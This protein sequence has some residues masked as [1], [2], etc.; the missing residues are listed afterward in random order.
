MI[1]FVGGFASGNLLGKHEGDEEVADVDIAG[2]GQA[3][4]AN[5]PGP[6]DDVERYR[7]PVTA[8]QPS[9][10]P[11]DALV[12][13]VIV[14]EFQCP[15]C[16]RVRPTVE[17]IEPE[18]GENLGIVWRNNPLPFH[19][20]AGPAANLALEAFEQGGAD[21]FWQMHDILFENQRALERADLERYAGQV[22]L[23]MG[24]VRA[25]LDNNEHRQVINDQAA[26]AQ[27]LGAR[28]TPAS[29]VNGRYISGAQPASGF[30]TAID[31]ELA[32]AQAA[33][34]S[35]TP[36]SDIYDVMVA[37]GLVGPDHWS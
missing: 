20:N 4:G 16:D 15:F 34:A 12:T 22:G 28:G 13:M 21:K 5:A 27:R 30:I 10:G 25:A 3:L 36:R 17:R 19:Q 35:G 32:R 8:D 14:S 26:L 11:A 33:I 6:E 18:Y 24:Q 37:N 1:A 31:E 29:F 7:V 2:D 9:K 23:D